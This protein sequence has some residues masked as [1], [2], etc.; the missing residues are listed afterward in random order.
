LAELE[1]SVEQSAA[2]AT[3]LRAE[4]ETVT[5]ERDNAQREVRPAS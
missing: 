4:L 2:E 1:A 3:R 5:E